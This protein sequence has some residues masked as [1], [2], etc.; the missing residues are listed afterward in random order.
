MK[1]G[2]IWG[3]TE[4]IFQK[5]N[6]EIH[7]IEIKQG[8]FCSTH[9]HNNKF[10]AFY[11]ESGSLKINV[12]QKAYELTDET[13]IETGDLT[14]VKPGLYHSFEALTDCICYEIYWTELD[15]EDIERRTVGGSK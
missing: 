2:K 14:V 7:R 15:H 6:F 12:E 13:I 3:F 9:K 4:A 8:G 10:N 11:M 5:H 1:Q